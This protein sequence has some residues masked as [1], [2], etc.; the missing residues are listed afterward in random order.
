MRSHCSSSAAA[1]GGLAWVSTS[2][3]NRSDASRG[4]KGLYAACRAYQIRAADFSTGAL[5]RSD[6]SR[7]E[8][9][10]IRLTI[11]RASE[12]RMKSSITGGVAPKT[13]RHSDAESGAM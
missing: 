11:V 5:Q 12:R 4:S 9:P 2:P 3:I 10:D 1:K 8:A 7:E 13:A 6:A